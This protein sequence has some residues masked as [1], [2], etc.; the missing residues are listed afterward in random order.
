[1]AA[2]DISRKRD[3]IELCFIFPYMSSFCI[4]DHLID[5]NLVV[6]WWAPKVIK[7]DFRLNGEYEFFWQ[8]SGEYLY[9]KYIGSNVGGEVLTFTWNW[10]NNPDRLPREVHLQLYKSSNGV[11]S[12]MKLIHKPFDFGK[13]ELENRIRYSELWIN[14]FQR[15]ANYWGNR[16]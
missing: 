12:F 1:M 2:L 4:Y 6:R 14:N 3:E 5:P 16:D 15:L 10:K 8:E 7:L 11:G 13:E 9:G